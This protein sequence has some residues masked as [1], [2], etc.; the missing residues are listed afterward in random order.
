MSAQ[1]VLQVAHGE[2]HSYALLRK[3]LLL[4]CADIVVQQNPLSFAWEET[5]QTE[6]TTN[7][8]QTFPISIIWPLCCNV[9]Y[10]TR[11]VWRVSDTIML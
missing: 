8:T 11:T 1:C 10:V 4:T 9:I 2:R 6:R 3:N 7:Q 5:N